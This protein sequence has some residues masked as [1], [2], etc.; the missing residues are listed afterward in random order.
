MSPSQASSSWRFSARLVTFSI[1]LKASKNQDLWCCFVIRKLL[2][3]SKIQQSAVFLSLVLFVRFCF[4]VTLCITMHNFLT[5][6]F[7]KIYWRIFLTIFLIIFW[8]IVWH[9]NF[10]TQMLGFLLIFVTIFWRNAESTKS[11]SGS[12]LSS[13]FWEAWKRNFKI[14]KILSFLSRKNILT[15]FSVTL[16]MFSHETSLWNFSVDRGGAFSE[17]ILPRKRYDFSSKRSG[18]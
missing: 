5:D 9:S 16:L 13:L 2:L 7:D 10:L 12:I 1:Q 11:I 14:F 8:Q 6:F 4:S 17:N 15:L 18:K 3:W